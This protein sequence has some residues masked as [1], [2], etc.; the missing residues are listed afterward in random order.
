MA[1]PNEPRAIVGLFPSSTPVNGSFN[2]QPGG[3]SAI[4]VKG[5]GF[6][7]RDKV[8]WGGARLVTTY[9]DSTQLTA[10]V[11]KGMLTKVGDVAVSVKDPVFLITAEVQ[12]TFR[13]VAAR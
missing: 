8:Y 12:A 6:T 5:T 1:L 11:P 4:A 10:L 3:Q 2:V 13:I 7:R 9:A